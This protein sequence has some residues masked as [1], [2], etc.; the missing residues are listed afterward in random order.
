MKNLIFLFS[1]IILFISSCGS[2][3]TKLNVDD[4]KEPCDFIDAYI[5]NYKAQIKLYENNKGELRI[6]WDSS[7]HKKLNA[8]ENLIHKIKK[9]AHEVIEDDYNGDRNVFRKESKDCNDLD[10]MGELLEELETLEKNS[11][12]VLCDCVE[13]AEGD[14]EK[15]KACFVDGVSEEDMIK[16]YMDARCN[17]Y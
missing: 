7:D 15:I 6:N 10:D 9:R 14:E 11:N 17:N 2:D 1:I 3:P 16:L 13:S 8:L 12:E 4:L 5:D